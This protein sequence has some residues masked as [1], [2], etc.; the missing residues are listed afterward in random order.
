M[1]LNLSTLTLKLT[2]ACLLLGSAQAADWVKLTSKPGSKV[3]MDGTSSIHDWYVEGAIIRGTFEV[4]PEF[5]TD[6]TLKSVKSLTTT[7]VNPKVELAIPVRS[8]KSSGGQKMDE[9]M[10][11]AMNAKEHKDITY[12]LKEMVVKGEVP[13]SGTPVKFDTKG[14]LTVNGVTQPCNMEVTMERVDDSR[15]KF[16]GTQKL[17]MTDFKI[18]PPAPSLAGGAIT[19]GDDITVK[20]EWLVGTTPAAK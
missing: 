2:A 18:T 10:Q 15:V 16:I 13:A 4:E 12:K 8:L 11:E 17:K 7:E 1:K 6:K 19:T 9:I 5:L 3:R 14:E 20:F